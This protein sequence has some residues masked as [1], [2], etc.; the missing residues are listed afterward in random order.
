M[1]NKCQQIK[2]LESDS[3]KVKVKF[4]ESNIIMRISKALLE[5]KVRNGFYTC[6]NLGF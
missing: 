1:K 2:I 3:T 6:V 4:I 5:A